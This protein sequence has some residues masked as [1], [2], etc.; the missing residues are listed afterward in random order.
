ML[1]IAFGYKDSKFIW[2]GTQFAS[3]WRIWLRVSSSGTKFQTDVNVFTRSRLAGE[4]AIT[5]PPNGSPVRLEGVIDIQVG[6]DFGDDQQDRK[7]G[8]KDLRG[9]LAFFFRG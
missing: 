9:L 2:L 1:Q 3:F 6:Y 8:K 7:Y 4:G 5:A